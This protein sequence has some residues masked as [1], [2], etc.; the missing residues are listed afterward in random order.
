MAEA[1]QASRRRRAQNV[2]W[3]AA[4]DYSFRPQF[5]ALGSDGEP[6]LYLNCVAG[7]G[8]KWFAWDQFQPLFNAIGRASKPKQALFDTVF[9]LGLESSLFALESPQRPALAELRRSCA[10]AF[11][12]RRSSRDDLAYRLLTARWLTVLGKAVPRGVLMLPRERRLLAELD[13]GAMTDQEL[14]DHCRRILKEYF[15]F[16]GNFEGL[17]GLR[18]IS[19][20]NWLEELFFLIF[21]T[22]RQR[23][24]MEI[25]RLSAMGRP[26]HKSGLLTRLRL[27]KLQRQ[28]TDRDY[29][30]AWFG[31][32]LLPARESSALERELCSGVHSRCHLYFSSGERS[33]EAMTLEVQTNV[34]AAADQRQRNLDYYRSHLDKYHQGI[35]SL[36][37]QIRNSLQ[38]VPETQREPS[39]R[40]MLDSSRVWRGVYLNDS[41]IF[42]GG[43]GQPRPSFSVTLALDASASRLEAQ[44]RIAAQGYVIAE[45]LRLCG[46]PLQVCSFCSLRSYTV[47]R[48][49][50]TGEEG[51]QDIFS[52]FAAGWNRDG[53]AL[54]GIGALMDRAP[55]ENRLLIL[56]TDA[57]PNDDTPVPPSG[58]FRRTRDY[59]GELAVKDAA[60][61][62]RSL[63]KRGIPVIA[64]VTGADSC[65]EP[66][67]AIYG[68]GFVR[69]QQVEQLA[70]LVGRLL[71]SQISMLD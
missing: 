19:I 9:W 24:P 22:G 70:P 12:E 68:R 16:S 18:W 43:E 14:L 32:P 45:S 36:S 60:A 58:A 66:A 46:V 5:L 15:H 38:I 54:R 53:L 50:R 57:N 25:H 63:V 65:L 31:K 11:L 17:K 44:E 62:A 26:I 52:Y 33:D 35:Q 8:R 40:G 56:L 49:F 7:L 30:A 55:A 10:S 34:A 37:A 41:R 2:Q 3:A 64:V 39:R 27:W 20:E 61:E 21:A 28:R 59:S 29:I 51:A 6:S 42:M 48:V 67:Q 71:R 13:C 1:S 4:G 69:I 23:S 47:I